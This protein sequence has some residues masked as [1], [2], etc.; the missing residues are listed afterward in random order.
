MKSGST[1]GEKFI[2]P[3]IYR[4]KGVLGLLDYLIMLIAELSLFL[5]IKRTFRIC[6]NPL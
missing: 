6:R 3:L 4:R 2:N 5:F 1:L